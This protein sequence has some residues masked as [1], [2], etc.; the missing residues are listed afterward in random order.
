MST[1]PPDLS[2][3][4]IQRE[5]T[6]PSRGRRGL[7]LAVVAVLLLALLSLTLLRPRSVLVEV[8]SATATGGGSI[9]AA[10]ISASG[11]VVARTK[12]SVSAKVLGRLTYLGVQEGS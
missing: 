3:L 12:A 7:W 2:R 8:A 1:S 5:P 6:A 9:T 11:Y 4:R 10:G